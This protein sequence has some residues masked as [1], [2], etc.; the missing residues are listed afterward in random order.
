MKSVKDEDEFDIKPEYLRK[1]KK[2]RKG[3]YHKFKSVKELRNYIKN[4]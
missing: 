3:K 1:L 4:A 2:I